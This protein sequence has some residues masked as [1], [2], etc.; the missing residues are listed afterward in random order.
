MIHFRFGP[1]KTRRE[2]ALMEGI[3]PAYGQA[4]QASLPDLVAQLDAALAARDADHGPEP[5]LV[6]PRPD[7]PLS[8]LR[9]L[10]MDP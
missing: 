3:G 5:E 4:L 6:T 2:K 1:P 7:G 10:L 9:P 8:N